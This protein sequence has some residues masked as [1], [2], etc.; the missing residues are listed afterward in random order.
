M[1]KNG[2]DPRVARNTN[3]PK[4]KGFCFNIKQNCRQ[5][6]KAICMREIYQL[7][8]FFLA[9]NIINPSFSDFTYFFLLNVIGISKLMFS[10]LVLTGQLSHIVGAL[11]YKAFCRNVE[12]RTMVLWSIITTIISNFF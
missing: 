2:V 7:V 5:I 9:N 3:V 1:I 11:V 6:G 10:V 12:A 8:I 4:R